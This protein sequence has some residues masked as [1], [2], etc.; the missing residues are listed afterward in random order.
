MSGESHTEKAQDGTHLLAFAGYFSWFGLASGTVRPHLLAVQA[1]HKCAGMG[2]PLEKA[3][4]L[5][6]LLEALRLKK[7][8]APR[9]LGVTIDRLKWISQELETG[10]FGI[11]ECQSF[12]DRQL[13]RMA[14]LFGFFFLYWA[15]EYVQ[16]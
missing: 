6:I 15:S 3:T 1:A 11:K 13:L 8:A 14:V 2:D 7:P 4:R 9:K 16:S 5:W 10:N 12:R